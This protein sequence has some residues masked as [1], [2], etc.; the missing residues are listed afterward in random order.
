MADDIYG[1][2]DVSFVFLLRH[3]ELSNPNLKPYSIANQRDGDYMVLAKTKKDEN[4]RSF[5]NVT[6]IGTY[7]CITT[8][9][10]SSG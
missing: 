6:S 10:C 5:P 9:I 3:Q 8:D 2:E 1:K 4:V 7:T